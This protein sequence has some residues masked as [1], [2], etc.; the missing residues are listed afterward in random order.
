MAF[1]GFMTVRE[2]EAVVAGNKVVIDRLEDSLKSKDETIGRV[3]RERDGLKTQIETHIILGRSERERNKRISA[4]RDALAAE[5]ATLKA[6]RDGLLNEALNLSSRA[7][8]AETRVNTYLDEI[9][10]LKPDAL[11]YRERLRRDR[12][13]MAAKRKRNA[14]AVR[15]TPAAPPPA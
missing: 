13:A 3:C 5:L 6:E 2:H 8:L 11:K 4:A 7:K 1:L 10:A 15:L 14:P 9:E 12:E